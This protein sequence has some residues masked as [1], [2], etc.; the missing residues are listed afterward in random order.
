MNNDWQKETVWQSGVL[1]SNYQAVITAKSPLQAFFKGTDKVECESRVGYL[2]QMQH[3]KNLIPH[4]QNYHSSFVVVCLHALPSLSVQTLIIYLVTKRASSHKCNGNHLK[5]NSNW[6]TDLCWKQKGTW[7]QPSS[8]FWNMDG[9]THIILLDS[10]C[11]N[12]HLIPMIQ[13]I[14][15]FERISLKLFKVVTIKQK[16]M[17]RLTENLKNN[18]NTSQQ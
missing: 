6:T 13:V 8:K 12:Q 5:H 2:H 9:S 17:D 4:S 11:H 16:E 1:Y 15:K 3:I 18:N 14:A 10:L 7:I